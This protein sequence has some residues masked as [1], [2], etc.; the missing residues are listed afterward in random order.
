MKQLDKVPNVE[1]IALD[2]I[3]ILSEWR[4]EP[5]API[6]AKSPAW[7]EE[8]QQREEE[9]REVQVESGDEDLDIIET[10][11]TT[12]TPVPPSTQDDAST[13]SIWR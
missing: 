9:E 13:P 1:A 8:E 7:L 4:A 2:N 12:S 5:E 11:V 3:N 10:D 6:M